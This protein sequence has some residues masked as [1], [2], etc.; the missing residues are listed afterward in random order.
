M[1][2]MNQANDGVLERWLNQ[3]FTETPD[4]LVAVQTAKAVA[5][6]LRNTPEVHQLLQALR[7]QLE[8]HIDCSICQAQL[9]DFLHAQQHPSPAASPTDERF[10]DL[11]THLALCPYCTAAYVQV[12]AWLV[13]VPTDRVPVAVAYPVF[14][15]GFLTDSPTTTTPSPPVM[16]LRAMLDQARAE[17]QRW[18]DD[19][20]GGLFV[21]FGSGL[22]PQTA[23]GWTIKSSGPGML[24]DQTVLAADEVAGWEIEVSAFADEEKGKQCRIE[25]ALYPYT[26]PAMSPADISVT[27]YY[28]DQMLTT[29]TDAGG[30]AQFWPIPVAVLSELAVHIAL[31]D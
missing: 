23:A 13:E 28:A 1:T 12:A 18:L 14:E 27:L 25:V 4:V 8:D 6:R 2:D 3:L 30:V 24:L 9:P 22:Q 7:G 17:G 26:E 11:R 19:T 31:T 15:L 21:M 16:P 5:T 20:I 10:A 29:E